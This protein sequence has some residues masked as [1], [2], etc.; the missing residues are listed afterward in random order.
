MLVVYRP[1]VVQRLIGPSRG[2]WDGSW[3]ACGLGG[4]GARTRLVVPFFGAKAGAVY[5]W[6]GW[7]GW[8]SDCQGLLVRVAGGER[9]A[10]IFPVA[11]WCALG[12]GQ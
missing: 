4:L 11:L 10:G 3:A 1:V 2:M 9:G 8:S 7:S 12:V 5:S 6:V